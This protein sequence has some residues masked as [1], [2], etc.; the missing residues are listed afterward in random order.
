M[1][2]KNNTD[3]FK[4]FHKLGAKY[5]MDA[6]KKTFEILMKKY[7]FNEKAASNMEESIYT[8][9]IS[10]MIEMYSDTETLIKVKL[11]DPDVVVQQSEFINWTFTALTVPFYQSLGDTIGY[12]NGKWEFNYGDT[13]AGPEYVNELIYEFISL[14]G[15][16]DLSITNWLASDDTILYMATMEVLSTNVKDVNDFGEKLRMEYLKSKKLIENRDPGQTTNDSLEIQQNIKWDK[17]PYNSRS[18][19]AG[20]AMRSGC[21]GIFFIGKHNRTKLIEFAVECSRITHNSAIAILGSI[22]AALFTAYSLERIPINHWPHKLLK[23]LRSDEIDQYMK[24]S[25]PK[26]Y[27]LYARDK[28]NFIGQWEKYVTFRFT[29][30]NPRLDLKY[31]KNPVQRYKYLSE[32]F[33]KGCDI[34]GSC[35]DDAVIMAYDALLQ[36]EGVFEKLLIY[37]ILHPGDSDTIGSIAF[38][39][40][41]GFYHSPRNEVLIGKRFDELEFHDQLHDL[42]DKNFENMAKIYYY[43]LYL[44]I[45]RKY[46]KK[47]VNR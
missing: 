22:V 42:M 1:S 20:S 8:S 19:G 3:F 33:S 34:P 46:L 38:S 25:R 40:F 26:E 12:Y 7:N 16:N 23:L 13:K 30:I 11:K 45:S 15:V 27:P 24:K 2:N 10:A 44:S 31:M 32:K 29:G 43:D 41:G 14:G 21:I 39:W 5:L 9:T 6:R 36:S 28:I 17:L 47:L 4:R 35:G 37:S 18:I